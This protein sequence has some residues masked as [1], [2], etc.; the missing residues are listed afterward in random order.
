MPD[1]LSTPHGLAVPRPWPSNGTPARLSLDEAGYVNVSEAGL[2]GP[3]TDLTLYAEDVGWQRVV[4]GIDREI[5]VGSLKLLRGQARAYFMKNPMIQRGVK[6]QAFYCFG[7]GMTVRA[8][9]EQVNEV[10]QAFL[11]DKQNQSELTSHEARVGKEISLQLEGNLFFCFFTRPSTGQVRI[12]TIPVDDVVDI[13]TN[14]EDAKESWYYKRAWT[15]N[16]LDLSTGQTT[17]SQQLAYYPD[18]RYHPDVP[19]ATI[20][21]ASVFWDQPV[22]HVKTGGLSDMRFGVPEV[23]AALDWA[24]SVKSDLENYAT[25]KK[26]LSRFAWSMTTQGGAKGVAAAKA[27]LQTTVASSEPAYAET[28]PPPVTASTFLSGGGTQMSPMRTAGAQPS[29]D[30]GRRLWLMVA[31]AFGLPETFW[32]EASVGSHATAKTLDRPTELKMRDRQILWADIYKDILE[33]VVDQAAAAPAG[34]LGGTVSIDA[35]GKKV[36]DLGQDENGQDRDRTTEVKFPPILDRDIKDRV[37]SVVNATTLGGNGSAG[38]FDKRTVVQLL[39]QALGEDDID[40]LLDRLA[41]NDD[42]PLLPPH[43]P[44]APVPPAIAPP[45]QPP[46]TA[47]NVTP[48]EASMVEAARR[49]RA[50]LIKVG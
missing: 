21:A 48:Q 20:G 34:P 39:L 44:N 23:Y 25:T 17:P 2:Y 9:D 6:I 3:M 13:I 16:D 37:D 38:T 1:Y 50:M 40:E 47:P 12:R 4:A 29:P 22:Y 43:D 19:P 30:E 28:N 46:G 33:F 10:I 49:L 5:S 15:R 32:G 41:P 8:S 45:G 18:W 35:D 26:A 7:Q 31:S 24:A 11:A 36:I 42:E 27:K 14:P